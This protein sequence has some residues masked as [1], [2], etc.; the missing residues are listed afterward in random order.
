MQIRKRAKSV[1][2]GKSE[3][4][5]DKDKKKEPE[6]KSVAKAEE[7]K[8]EDVS[9]EKEAKSVSTS[10]PS[11]PKEPNEK[12]VEKESELSSTPEIV[13]GPQSPEV[14]TPPDEF[15]TDTMSSQPA[16]TESIKPLTIEPINPNEDT[17]TKL[18]TEPG[19]KTETPEVNEELSATPPPSAFTIQGNNIEAPTRENGKK[20]HFLLYFLVVA[21]FSF[22]LGLGAMAAVTYGFVNIPFLKDPSLSSNLKTVMKSNPIPN[23]LAKAS[24]TP[25]PE[26]K[27]KPTTVPTEKPLDLKA[28]TI[29]VLN[30]SGIVGKAAEVKTSLTTAGFTVSTTGNADRNDYTTT[31]VAVKKSV[32]K[33]YITKLEEELKKTFK[34]EAV[35]TIPSDA[36]QQSD[37]TITL[38]KTP[39]N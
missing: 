26:P 38:G 5:K 29:S 37:V 6:A 39:A 15:L 4:E 8:V 9:A 20:K 25:T 32:D 23:P 34:V 22:L 7:E 14:V 2:F 17:A 31:Q 24:P 10:Q 36:S 35:S 19:E 28:Y 27:P 30:G 11:E 16:T 18:P 3:K 33:A 21:F 13:K 1:S 12:I